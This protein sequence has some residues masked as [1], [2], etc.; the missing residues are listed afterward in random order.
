MDS[1]SMGHGSAP[2]V[3][4]HLSAKLSQVGPLSNSARGIRREVQHLRAARHN[5]GLVSICI[6]HTCTRDWLLMAWPPEP[7]SP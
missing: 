5:T 3:I 7:G 1:S 6:L 2:K 4:L